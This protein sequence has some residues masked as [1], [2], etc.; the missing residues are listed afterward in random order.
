MT[1]TSVWEKLVWTPIPPTIVWPIKAVVSPAN[2]AFRR[3][4]TSM[5]RVTTTAPKIPQ[6]MMAVL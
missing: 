4:M 2:K 1:L 3:P 5:K 6:P